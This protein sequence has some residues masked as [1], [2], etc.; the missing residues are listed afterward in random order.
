MSEIASP[1][2]YWN[3]Q[4]NKARRRAWKQQGIEGTPINKYETFG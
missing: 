3:R 1:M 4:M 2:K